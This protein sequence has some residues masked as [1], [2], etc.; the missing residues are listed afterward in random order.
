M[1]QGDMVSK[2]CY[3]RRKSA[4][5]I[6]F[7]GI[8]ISIWLTGCQAK[9]KRSDSLN[10]GRTLYE[11]EGTLDT[12]E[13]ILNFSETITYQN[14]KEVAL[15]ELY[16]H[17]YGNAYQIYDSTKGIQVLAVNSISKDTLNF[18][19]LEHNQLLKIIPEKPLEPGKTIQFEISCKFL[20]PDL[21]E[22][23]GY[24]QTQYCFSFFN[25][26]MAVYDDN[27]WDFSPMSLVGDGRY[28]DMS[29]FLMKITVPK[30]YVVACGGVERKKDVKEETVTYTFEN[31]NAR[32]ICMAISDQYEIVE[33]E[34]G[35]IKIYAYF[36]KNVVSQERKDSSMQ[37][38]KDSLDC[39]ET[40]FG[41]YPYDTFR[42]A[43]I[44]QKPNINVAMEYSGLI[45]MP[46]E[47]FLENQFVFY[48]Q[49]LSHE[50]AHQWFYGIIGNNE[51]TEAWL[52]EGLSTFAVG[53]YLEKVKGKS[54]AETYS[55]QGK[56]LKSDKVPINKEITEY[57]DN[58]Y[59]M[60]CYYKAQ[61]FLYEL[62][63]RMGE[64]SFFRAMREYYDTYAFKQANTEGFIKIMKHNSAVSIDDLVSNYIALH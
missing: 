26:Q 33:D 53:V 18:E 47:A 9:E 46:R 23:F 62:R 36:E 49:I 58:S 17:I 19:V 4:F 16:L 42:M 48:E 22:R 3:K 11:I 63:E 5:I 39:Y 2:A 12:K 45:Y 61:Y 41:D 13:H 28:H 32:D 54:L 52:D 21:V 50:I 31:N 51:T 43:M 1:N 27:G 34:L 24:Y 57:K 60:E 7:L 25:P 8:A 14:K 6:G 30:D 56:Y 64:E 55:I 35:D 40:V 59:F 37:Q 29:D 10:E 44:T 38:I 20:I 15:S